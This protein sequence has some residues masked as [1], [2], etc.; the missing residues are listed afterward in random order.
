VVVTH[1][2]N[3]LIAAALA[4]VRAQ[5]PMPGVVIAGQELAIGGAI[6]DLALIAICGT[7]EDLQGQIWYLPL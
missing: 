3:T 5:Q 4:R 7:P 2:V 6:D 1:D